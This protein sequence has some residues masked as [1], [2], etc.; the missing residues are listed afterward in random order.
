MCDCLMVNEVTNLTNNND[1]TPC[2][3]YDH[4]H[5]GPPQ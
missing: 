2:L 4:S 3:P 5:D 1:S